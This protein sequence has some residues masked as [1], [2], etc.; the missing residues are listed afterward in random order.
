MFGEIASS[1]D[2]L[3]EAAARKAED[4]ES[5]ARVSLVSWWSR[6]RPFERLSDWR[7]PARLAKIS[8]SIERLDAEIRETAYRC[9]SP[10]H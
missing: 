9:Y 4:G 10:F 3:A 8:R 1:E 2:E 7:D 6:A 5:L